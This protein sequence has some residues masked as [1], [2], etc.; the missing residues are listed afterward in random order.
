SR[1][2]VFLLF[3][4][5]R[6][7]LQAAETARL[8]AIATTAEPATSTTSTSSTSSAT[9]TLAALA[10][11]TS[12]AATI[13]AIAATARCTCDAIDHVVELAARYRA[14]RSLFALEHAHE[15][16]LVDAVADDVERL[17]QALGTVGLDV[18]RARHRIGR[19][20]L[21]GRLRL[22][23]RLFVTSRGRG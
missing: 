23:G 9:T 10:A 4:L 19:R 14:V 2:I 15:T 22:G 6:A 16:D 18:E 5:L 3:F 21:L 17:E 13:V 12:T 7:R 11:S 8:V 1:T 20:I